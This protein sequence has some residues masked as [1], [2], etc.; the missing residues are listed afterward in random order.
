VNVG[1]INGFSGPVTLSASVTT[2]GNPNLPSLSL[3]QSTV[4]L[5][6]QPVANGL[7]ISVTANLYVSAT[8]STTPGSYT[9]TVTASGG[10]IAHT[11]YVTVI[12][13]RVDPTVV[14]TLSKSTVYYGV[15]N[16]I[17]LNLAESNT[18]NIAVYSQTVYVLVNGNQIG[19]WNPPTSSL[20]PGQSMTGSI[21]WNVTSLPVGIY[22]VTAYAPLLRYENIATNRMTTRFDV[23]RCCGAGFL[24]SAPANT[25][26]IAQG[27]SGT[28]QITLSP[29]FGFHGGLTVPG[30]TAGGLYWDFTPSL[31]PPVNSHSRFFMNGT[32]T[33]AY[34]GINA[35]N[36][37][38][39]GTYTL[40][41]VVSNDLPISQSIPVNVTVIP[42]DFTV[43]AQTNDIQTKWN[44]VPGD[45]V[46]LD[47]PTGFSGNVS[48]T[49]SI[50]PSNNSPTVYWNNTGNVQTGS[51][52]TTA[53]LVP[54]GSAS[55]LL[56]IYTYTHN[57]TFTITVTAT[58]VSGTCSS[59]AQT[60]SLSISLGVSPY[61]GGG[62]SVAAGTLITLADRSQV[63]VQQLQVG[64][65]LLSYDMATRQY[66]YTTIT[67][68]VTV[69]THDQMV[70][71]TGT[72]KPLIV[73]QNP[74]QKLYVKLPDGTVTLMSVTDLKVGYDLFDAI[75]Q[76][77]SLITD[78]HHENGGTHVMYDIYT[79]APGN[80]IANGYLDPLKV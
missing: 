6:N 4:T 53:T 49:V 13:A 36:T 21:L 56:I 20:S 14:M 31:R 76:T 57:G 47:S 26:Y 40:N 64:I 63:P 66:V 41:M 42:P 35:T 8:N 33:N 71:S 27:G 16:M 78:I 32:V 12:V 10:G 28:V 70:I 1:S 62:G 37:A 52:Q 67:R 59:P 48:L 5:P 60:H 65:R 22:N 23:N 38:T 30:S 54:G 69:V 80:Y 79:T 68:F 18:G 15:N 39:L 34:V 73:D 46:Y 55:R 17:T 51:R 72:G 77:W 11:T 3:A 74:A 19:S 24:V 7:P 75:A 25:A 44:T 61:S 43:S 29:T 9:V 2:T 50:S 45:Y 58:C